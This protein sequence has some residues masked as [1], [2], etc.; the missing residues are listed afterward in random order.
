MQPATSSV[1]LTDEYQPLVDVSGAVG[2][3][4][5]VDCLPLTRLLAGAGPSD[6]DSVQLG[7]TPGN[8]QDLDPGGQGAVI[9]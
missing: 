9:M 5:D 7:D 4:K 3:L 6:P 1:E 2:A 8:Q